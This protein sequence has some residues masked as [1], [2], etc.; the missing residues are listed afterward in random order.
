MSFGRGLNVPLWL[1]VL[2]NTVLYLFDFKREFLTSEAVQSATLS[3]QRV[4]HVEGSYSLPARVL[5]V[6]YCISDDVLEEHF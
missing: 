5:S 1:V 3:L 6:C 2:I 4:D